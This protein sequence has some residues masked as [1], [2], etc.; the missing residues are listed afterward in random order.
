M[1]FQI[2]YTQTSLE[3]LEEIC[4]RSWGEH[5]RSTARFTDALLDHVELLASF[6]DLGAY[7]ARRPDV[8]RLLHSHFTS[9]IEC[10]RTFGTLKSF[11]FG[12]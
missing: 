12:T 1:D 3:D 6:P 2:F 10:A 8:R 7:W 5:P 4:A 11:A 9:T